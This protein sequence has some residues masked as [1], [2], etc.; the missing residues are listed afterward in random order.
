[1]IVFLVNYAKSFLFTYHGKSMSFIQDLQKIKALYERGE[2]IIDYIKNQE[3]HLINS[4]EA[5]TI[6]YD[7]QAG[8]YT[9]GDRANPEI[10]QQ[11]TEA[12]ANVINSLGSFNSILEAGVGE[13][14]TLANLIPKLFNS[15]RVL[16]FDLSWS[17]IKYAQTYCLDKGLEDPFLFVGDLF[18]MPLHDNAIDIVYTLHSMEPNGGREAEALAELYRVTNRYVVLLEP[19]YELASAEA[20]QRMERLGYVRGLSA[21]AEALGM[22]IVEHR[23]FDYSVNPLNPTG[24]T[25]IKKSS[26]LNSPKNSLACPVTKKPMQRQRD[27]YYCSESMLAYPIIDGIPCLTERNAVVATH[28]LEGARSSS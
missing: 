11:Y 7:L 18:N 4:T 10:K 3:N 15:P 23:L 5:I 28:Y 21:T 26:S 14:T 17:R 24:L 12:L 1:M 8:S 20:Q 19:A 9:T 16:G 6:S 27:S 22:E 25:V 2:N 13:A